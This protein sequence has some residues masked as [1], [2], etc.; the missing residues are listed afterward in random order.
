M[1]CCIIILSFG[2]LECD[3]A[4]QGRCRLLRRAHQRI[5]QER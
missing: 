2:E 1:D 3:G 5:E 4:S